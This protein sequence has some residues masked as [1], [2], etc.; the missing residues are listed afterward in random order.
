M[1]VNIV[2]GASGFIGK[3]LVQ[4]LAKN[5]KD[6]VIAIVRNEKSDISGIDCLENV[7]I[8]FCEM[9]NITS[10]LQQIKKKKIDCF[11]HLA[12]EGST[13]I[14]RANY[15]IQMNNVKHSLDAFK[16]AEKL[17]CQ[18]FLCAGT[19]SERILEQIDDLSNVSQ[20]MI[21]AQ[22]KKTLHDLLKIISKNSITRLVW[23]QFSN[24]YGPGNTTGN[25]ISYTLSELQA[26][27][28]PAYGS[29]NQPYNFIYIDDLI[30]GV[31]GLANSDLKK[32]FYFIGSDEILL[33]KDYL[34]QIPKIL[35]YDVEL[36][37]GK[38]PDDGV[39]YDWEWFDNS[40]L[41]QDTGYTS[42]YSFRKGIAV[43][44]E[45]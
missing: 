20:N 37:I 41:K 26:G 45:H 14:Q 2:T 27:R 13:G 28:I 8:I 17:N 21:Y 23:M 44:M 25:L 33:L 10:L 1:A 19:I 43:L 35:N 31:C 15:E 34:K 16:I 12:W 22:A 36:G 30:H 11:F 40:D 18:K 32:E 3:K 6:T 7:E 39:K 5:V 24:V 9:S 42:K 29:A 38:R 4:E